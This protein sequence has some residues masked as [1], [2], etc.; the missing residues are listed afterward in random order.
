MNSE[1][2]IDSIERLLATT[3]SIVNGLAEAQ[4]RT[5]RQIEALAEAQQRTEERLQS[6]D[7]AMTEAITGSYA[8]HDEHD[9]RMEEMSRRMEA[10]QADTQRIWQYLTGQQRNGGGHE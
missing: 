10:M 5:E 7:E 4:T 8:R 1:N 3:A 9:R 2:R 6:L